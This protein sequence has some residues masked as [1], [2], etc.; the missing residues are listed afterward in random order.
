METKDITFPTCFDSR[1]VVQAQ[2][3]PSP[4][5]AP[6]DFTHY[7]YDE[8]GGGKSTPRSMIFEAGRCRSS[9]TE[10]RLQVLRRKRQ[11]SGYKRQLRDGPNFKGA[12]A[13]RKSRTGPGPSGTPP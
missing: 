11:F 10:R 8:Q 5:S 12:V 3:Q 1:Q 2:G 6:V 7:S 4:G 9:R 13:R